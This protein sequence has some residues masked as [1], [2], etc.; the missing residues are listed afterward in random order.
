MMRPGAGVSCLTG[1][2]F[3]QLLRLEQTGA[4]SSATQLVDAPLWPTQPFGPNTHLDAGR[5]TRTPSGIRSARPDDGDID[6][7][8]TRCLG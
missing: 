8:R 5:Q 2:N 6:L 4:W 1:S 3:D 7:Q